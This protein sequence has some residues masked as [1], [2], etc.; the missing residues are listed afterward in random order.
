MVRNYPELS[1][2]PL[3]CGVGVRHP[4]SGSHQPVTLESPAMEV[5]TDLIRVAAESIGPDASIEDAN[6]VMIKRG[7]RLLFVID[8]AKTILGIITATDILGEKPMQHI[9]AHGGKHDE[10]RVDDIMTPQDRLQV[11]Q[12]ADVYHACVGHIVTS[13]KMAGRQHALVAE[14]SPSGDNQVIRGIFSMS[15]IAR[16]L[17]VNIETTEIARTFAEIET[18]LVR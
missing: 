6:R 11:L 18:M 1:S 9:V 16:Q 13:L 7:I 12:M 4:D 5:M 14:M 17:G 10:L 2:H 15:Q 8:A 3:R